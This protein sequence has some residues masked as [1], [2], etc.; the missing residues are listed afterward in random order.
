M[1][2][3]RGVKQKLCEQNDNPNLRHITWQSF[4]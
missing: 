3:Y 1:M 2:T 4:P